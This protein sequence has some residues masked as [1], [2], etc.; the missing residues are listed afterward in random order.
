MFSLGAKLNFKNGAKIVFSYKN[1]FCFVFKRNSLE[2]VWA[3]DFLMQVM[4]C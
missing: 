1:G 3:E 4:I 2:W